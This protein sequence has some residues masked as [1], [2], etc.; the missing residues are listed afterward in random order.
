MER[1]GVERSTGPLEHLLVLLM[2]R[3]MTL[4]ETPLSGA[5]PRETLERDD[6]VDGGMCE[7]VRQAPCSSISCH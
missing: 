2:A 5:I 7:P 4:P 1:V 6:L 3:I